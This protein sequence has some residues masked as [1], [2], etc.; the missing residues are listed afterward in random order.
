MKN[1]FYFFFG[2]L[3]I[4]SCNDFEE[5]INDD[6]SNFVSPV[7]FDINAVPYQNLSDYNFFSGNLKNQIPNPGVVP[8]EL[9]SPLF[10]DYAKK[11]RFLWMPQN[12]RASYAGDHNA[13]NFPTGTM[14]VKTF[15]YDHVQPGN[16]TKILETRLMIKKPE[17]WIFANYIWNEQQTEAHLDLTGDNVALSWIEAGIPKTAN[18]RIPSEAECHTCHKSNE[19]NVPLG[20]KPQN[21]NS[22]YTYANN[23]KNQLQKWRDIGYLNADYPSNIV[24]VVDHRDETKPLELRIRSYFDSNCSSCHNDTGH[25]NYMNLRLD[26]KDT[27]IAANMGVCEEPVQD[28]GPWLSFSPSHIIKPGDH[29]NSNLLHRLRSTESHLIMPLIGTSIRN[30]EAIDMVNQWITSLEPCAE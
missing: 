25:C 6:E 2:C 4:I 17:G 20:P 22:N 24:T 10:T 28:I 7:V 29:M 30:E 23:T 21:L 1:F 15:Y 5:P 8:Y 26:F 16:T 9:I 27:D 14:L 11:K 12:V 18:Y 13:I 3:F 19:V